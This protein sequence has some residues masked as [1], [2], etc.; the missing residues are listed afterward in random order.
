M[1]S[2]STEQAYRLIVENRAMTN[3][4]QS[5]DASSNPEPTVREA[6][7]GLRKVLEDGEG[8][9]FRKYCAI[10]IGKPGWLTF[11]RYELLTGL[12]GSIPGAVG[13]LLRRLFYRFLFGRMGYGVIIGRNVTIR[14]PHR[15]LLGDR[16]IIDDHAVLD[17]KG[18]HNRAI[19]L[20]DD[21]II[22]RNTALICKDGVIHLST[23]TNVSVNCTLI[24][25]TELS[26]GPRVLIA[27]HCYLIAGGNHGIDRLDIAPID[28]P[29]VEKGGI[30]ID[31]NVWLGAGVIVL[32][33]VRIGRDT[34]VAAGAVV[35][36][37]LDAFIIAGGVPARVLRDRRD[38][39][40]SASPV[41]AETNLF[42][43]TCCRCGREA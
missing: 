28:Q 29:R 19:V 41:E 9:A 42:A 10:N 36:R 40:N 14:H 12:L 23:R 38:N 3:H 21:V 39:S 11:I 1:C 13:Y 26:I 35:N 24:S 43:Q 27:G 25:E 22:G 18:E 2:S 15:I 6:V 34:V 5:T 8:S 37:P 20:D 33:G 17:A 32:D 30:Q 16:V 4:Q 7:T 31:Q